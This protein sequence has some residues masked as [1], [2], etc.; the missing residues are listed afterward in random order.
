M[1]VFIDTGI[2]AG[3]SHKGEDLFD[4]ASTLLNKAMKGEFG[5]IYTSD[6]IFDE[7]I[8]LIIARTKNKTLAHSFGDSILNSPRIEIL[9]IDKSLFNFAWKISKKFQDKFLSFTDC[10]TIAILKTYNISV[11]LSFDKHFDGLDGN[12]YRIFS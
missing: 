7:T 6:Y 12:Y 5:P 9:S 1:S 10:T 4:S 8:T 3:A 11:I 2:F